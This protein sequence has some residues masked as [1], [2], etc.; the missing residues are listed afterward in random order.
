VTLNQKQV[1]ISSECN[2]V[3][4]AEQVRSRSVGGSMQQVTSL[5]HFAA[6]AGGA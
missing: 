4:F 2:I 6:V 1:S 3:G 5:T